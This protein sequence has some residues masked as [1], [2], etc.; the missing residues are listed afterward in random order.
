MHLRRAQRFAGMPRRRSKQAHRVELLASAVAGAAAGVIIAGNFF[1]GGKEIRKRVRA[2]Y[3]VG[4]PTFRRSMGLLLGPPILEGNHVTILN[5]GAEIFPAMLSAIAAAQ[6]TITFE[7]FVLRTGRIARRFAEALAE[8]ARAGVRVHLL[9]DSIGCDC[10][11]G[12][13]RQLMEEAGVEIEIFRWI[14]FTRMNQRTHRKLLVIDGRVG[15]TGGVGIA[16]LWDGYGNA[17]HHWRDTHYRLEGP[18]VAQMQEAFLD[19]WMQTR[20]ELLHGDDYFPELK[21]AGEWKGQVIRSSVDEG[22]DSVRLMLLVSFAAARR[23]IRIGA[24]YFLP[25]DLLIDALCEA[26]QRGVEIQIIVPGPLIDTPLVRCVSRELWGRLLAAGVRIF[27]FQPTNF[28]CKYLIVDECWVSVGSTNIDNRSMHLNEE[29][30][31]NVLSEDFARQH[32]AVFEADLAQSLEVTEQA[33]RRRPLSE[34]VKG[35]AGMI[36]R[37]QM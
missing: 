33:W 12:A 4:D 14:H 34:K 22:S 10:V 9:Q 17:P 24:A 23:S 32:L 3:A 37:N 31:L 7:N 25:D 6:R 21:A 29:A 2:D 18:A 19:N 36:L 5:N 16:D 35:R 28:H 30:N 20:A 15:F 1:I 13:E 8:R 11:H 26:R 27:E